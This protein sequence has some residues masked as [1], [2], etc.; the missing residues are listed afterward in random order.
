MTQQHRTVL[1]ISKFA[2]DR[3][4]YRHYLQAESRYI[5]NISEAESGTD[6][7]L[8]CRLK[9]PDIIL[10]DFSLAD[11][12]G[13]DFLAN[14]S[15]QMANSRPPVI[16]I[17]GQGN[18]SVAVKAIKS[19]VYDY[20]VR[21]ETTPEFLL[22][23]VQS[24]IEN[25]ELCQKVKATEE[26]SKEALQKSEEQ[27][28]FLQQAA[29]VGFWDWNL[30]TNTATCSD[31][32]YEL[33]GLELGTPISY[34]ISL[35]S[36]LEQDK[37]RLDKH[38]RQ[39]LE[40]GTKLNIE[41]RILHPVWGVRWLAAIGQ[42]FYNSQGR[43]YRMMGMVLD[44]SERKKVE[45]ELQQSQRF[46][47]QI[48]ETVPGLVYIYDLN[49][50]LT[51]KNYVEIRITDTGKGIDPDFLPHIFE[52]FS[53]AVNSTTRGKDG[54][55]L[56]LSIVHHLVELHGG[57]VNAFS[58]GVGLGATFTVVLPLLEDEKMRV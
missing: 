7:L 30:V 32:Y 47:Q 50:Q 21:D 28:R 26:Q 23:A 40:Q 51:K 27:L 12:N 4:I 29:N 41:F 56:G 19:G 14:L 17:T 37:K 46:T 49:E 52:R 9:K 42:I 5:Y 11:I 1:I 55:G 45:E 31:K 36:V 13:L 54:L 15:E 18:E 10:L 53:Q 35:A 24:A 8:S 57:N 34:E 48:I 33:H 20:L 44:I 25:A 16:M 22:Q 38:V 6:G 3:E 2:E 58:A 43:S 39:A